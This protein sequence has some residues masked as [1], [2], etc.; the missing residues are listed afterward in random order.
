MADENYTVL[1]RRY[2]PQTFADLVGQEATARAL[3]N[4]L[5]GNRVAHAYLFTGARGV[6][7]TST[8]RILAKALNCEKGPTPTPCNE[9]E[10]CRS[11]TAGDDVDVIEIDGASNNSVDDARLLRSNI[12]THTTRARYKIYIIDEV[13]MLSKAAFNALL[14]TLE[15]P[16]PH[17][18]FIF[19]TT[20]VQKIPIT[21]LSRCQ[22]FDFAGISTERIQAQLK[23]I[24]EREGTP[25]DDEALELVAR[26]AGGSMRD[27][28][29]LLDQVLAFGGDR[30]TADQVRQLL[31]MAG[32]DRVMAL[33]EAVVQ[34]DAGQALNVLDATVQGGLQMGELVDQMLAYWRDLM[35]VHCAGEQARDLSTPSRCRPDVNRH[36]A[37]MTLDAVL[38]GLDV[39]SA[40]RAR[41]RDSSHGRTL[42][43]MALVRLGRISDLLPVAQLAQLIGQAPPAPAAAAP[44]PRQISAP[45]E[46]VKKKQ[47]SHAADAVPVAHASGS[48][49][50][51]PQSLAELWPQ[52][53]RSVG[54]LL[55]SDL[56]KAGPPAIF[57]PNSLVLRFPADY[58]LS[59]E[60]CQDPT[61]LARIEEVLKK[62]SGR[63]WSVKIEGASG[64]AA[65]TSPPAVETGPP[66]AARPR[67]NARAEAEKEPLVQRAVEALGAQIVRVDE[68]FGETAPSPLPLSPA[69]GERGRGEGA[70]EP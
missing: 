18:K 42:V 26:R 7:K 41:L 56:E 37:S 52:V 1:A 25:I 31:G 35:V 22:R 32:D 60:H 29:S 55:A 12:G 59:K 13:H 19:A 70:Q 8:A 69:A 9:C 51:P 15:E 67:R 44:A 39:L 27:A 58:N 16:P 45:P 38:A 6:G 50:P 63:P 30:I 40:T 21:I 57:G 53:L 5:K 61:R 64:P 10:I 54:P 14:K 68:G 11:I 34:G 65:P 3:V 33:A 23:T 2:R 28:Q 47:V 4:A 43:E 66:P 36:A 49:A 20:E 62:L 46:G 48:S 17:V 24:T